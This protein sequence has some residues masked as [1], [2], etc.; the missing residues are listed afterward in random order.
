MRNELATGSAGPSR[1]RS[2][3]KPFKGGPALVV[4]PPRP[5]VRA[6]SSTGT[7]S[8]A[9]GLTKSSKEEPDTEAVQHD[10]LLSGFHE[11]CI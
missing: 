7:L 11:T 4:T 10:G 2:R 5:A 6:I 3:S 1:L 8:Q 9:L